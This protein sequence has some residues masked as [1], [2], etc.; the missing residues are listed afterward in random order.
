VA[1]YT[2]LAELL[3]VQQMAA[4]LV[5]YKQLELLELQTQAAAVVAVVQALTVVQAVEEL[6]FYA[7]QIL[8]LL[9]S[10]LD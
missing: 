8:L 3:E 6:L 2:Q 1:V 5:E 9:Q 7:F 4:V 10:A